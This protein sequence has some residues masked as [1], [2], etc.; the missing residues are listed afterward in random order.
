MTS[1]WQATSGSTTEPATASTWSCLDAPRRMTTCLP[2]SSTHPA[3]PRRTSNWRTISAKRGSWSALWLTMITRSSSIP[4]RPMPMPAPPKSI[5]RRA[6]LKRRLFA[7]GRPWLL[8]IGNRTKVASPRVSGQVC[9][10][11][12]WVSGG[13]TC[14]LR[15]ARRP[16]GCSAPTCAGTVPT[17]SSPCSKRPSQRPRT[18]RRGHGG[19]PT[20][21]RRPMIRLVFLNKS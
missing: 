1:N 13:T 17:E 21:P 11:P 16:T 5:G 6:P 15:C 18:R 10:A 14:F 3:A 9:A 4:T 20:W 7:G 19:S 12:C 8:T 2:N